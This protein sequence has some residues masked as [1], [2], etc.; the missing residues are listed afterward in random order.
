MEVS[1]FPFLPIAQRSAMR[2]AT[3]FILVGTLAVVYTGG[4]LQASQNIDTPSSSPSCVNHQ[5]A[6][7]SN[8]NV[9][10]PEWNEVW[11]V[12]SETHPDYLLAD[13]LTMEVHNGWVFI[14]DF[15]GERPV[16]VFDAANGSFQQHV[17]QAG[18]GPGQIQWQGTL[19]IIRDD[20]LALRDAQTQTVS[21]FDVDS[22]RFLHRMDTPISYAPAISD[23]MLVQRP[24]GQRDVL[25]VAHEITINDE[26]IAIGDKLWEASLDDFTEAFAPFRENTIAKKGKTTIDDGTVYLSFEH[27][28]HLVALSESGDI[29]FETSEPHD[30]NPPDFVGKR[31]GIDMMEPPRNVYPTMTLNLDTDDQ[32]VY[33]LHSGTIVDEENDMDDVLTSTRLDVY[34][35]QTG[36]Y[37][38]AVSL[39]AATRNF[40]ITNDRVYLITLED[41]PRVVAFEKPEMLL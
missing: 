1:L 13:P 19:Q 31:E 40:R 22:G 23:A 11:H 32:Y 29:L 10:N 3:L 16:W 37:Q 9:V 12:E 2:S 6:P 26:R 21:I 27:A 18:T 4:A 28:S 7:S 8:R 25:A 33:A 36:A 34:D 20:Y 38:F 15:R 39:P 41:A 24:S 35:K 30:V 14:G 5:E 17:G